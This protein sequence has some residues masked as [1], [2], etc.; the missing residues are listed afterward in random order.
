MFGYVKTYTPEL[1]TKEYE[2]YKSVYC[3]LCRSMGKCTGCLSSLALNY[4]FVFLALVRLA[5]TEEEYQIDKKRCAVHP[6][7]KRNIMRQNDTL[8]YCAKASALLTY[9][10]LKDDTKDKKGLRRIFPYLTLPFARRAMSAAELP[11]LQNR[12]ESGLSALADI[13]LSGRASV[14]TP[15]HIFG[16][17]LAEVFAYGIG[18]ADTDTN[19]R[20]AREIGY[21]TGRW[22]YAIDAVD[23]IESDAKS[24]N[25]N[26]FLLLYDKITDERKEDIA[27]ALTLELTG[28][29]KAL[30]LIDSDRCS[31]ILDILRNILYMGMPACA[32]RVLTKGK[33]INN[34]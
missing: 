13:E 27:S 4:D 31:G 20:I 24:G 30:D 8:A 25:Y 22:I 15:A 7:E 3:G 26:P 2:F 1:K 16:E 32:E 10:K 28:I 33:N 5:L 21:H 12:I 34:E 6:I 9:S 23:D 14:D 29:E 19:R 11:T 18:Q 17:I